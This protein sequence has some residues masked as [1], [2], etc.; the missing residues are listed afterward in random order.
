MDITWG[1]T[2][3]IRCHICLKED[4]KGWEASIGE[5][6]RAAYCYNC[7]DYEIN[8]QAWQFRFSE[9]PAPPRLTNE[10]REILAKW[11]K[12]KWAKTGE[13]VCL[14]IP[15]VDRVIGRKRRESKKILMT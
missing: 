13:S 1:D 8:S 15:T 10:E 9:G 7:G 14:N 6:S 5:G 11:V 12:T 2:K 4:A 3:I